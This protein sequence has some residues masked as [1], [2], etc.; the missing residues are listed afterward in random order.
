[1][2]G[3][4]KVWQ[5]ISLTKKINLIDCPGVVYHQHNDSDASVVLKGEQQQVQPFAFTGPPVPATARAHA[6]PQILGIATESRTRARSHG[7]WSHF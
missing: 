7:E 6:T 5:Y 3:E 1:M 4:T 2:P